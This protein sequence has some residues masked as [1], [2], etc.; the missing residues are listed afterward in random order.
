MKEEID[1]LLKENEKLNE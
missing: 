1:G